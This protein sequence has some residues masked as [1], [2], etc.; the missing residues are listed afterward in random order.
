M[1]IKAQIHKV[2]SYKPDPCKYCAA[3]YKQLE[4]HPPN[5]VCRQD[6]LWIARCFISSTS[7]RKTCPGFLRQFNSDPTGLACAGEKAADAE[8][9]GNKSSRQ[10]LSAGGCTG[11]PGLEQSVCAEEPWVGVCCPGHAARP[12]REAREGCTVQQ[13]CNTLSS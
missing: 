8:E 7:P 12:G 4:K 6:T 2:K 13:V 9:P 1:E 3:K 11:H 5:T 10:C